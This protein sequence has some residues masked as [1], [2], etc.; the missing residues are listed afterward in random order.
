[1]YLPVAHAE[2]KFVT[3]DRAVLDR[4]DAAGQLVLRYRPL[5]ERTAAGADGQVP[6]PDNPN[7]SMANVAGVCDATGRVLGLMPHPERHIDRTHHPR[8]TRPET[9]T[10]GDGLAV[11]VNAV[12]YFVTVG[13]LEG[14][15]S[16]SPAKGVDCGHAF[17]C[18]GQLPPGCSEK[19]TTIGPRALAEFDFA[20]PILRRDLPRQG[21]AAGL[22]ARTREREVAADRRGDGRAVGQRD[23]QPK[24]GQ[25][26]DELA[27]GC[28]SRR[29]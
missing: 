23:F 21:P 10:T 20:D 3:R 13:S 27:P 17:R 11:F 6:F 8:W 1:M 7:G 14:G 12:E 18:S 2:G 29:D 24:M 19:R 15:T 25:A 22:G 5:S 28:R 26:E 16:L 4:L 9:E